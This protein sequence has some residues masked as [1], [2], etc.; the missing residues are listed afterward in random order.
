DPGSLA[1]RA[2][3][4]SV[5][6]H[7]EA[8]TETREAAEWYERQRTGLGDEFLAELDEAFE[9]INRTPQAFS[10]VATPRTGSEVRRYV[11]PRFPYSV[12]YEVRP[13]EVLILAVAH[14]RRRPGYWHQRQG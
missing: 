9:T 6:I 14:Q 11:V 1:A 7:D 10:R 3:L 13:D 5:R 12:F 2:F 4:V 8:R